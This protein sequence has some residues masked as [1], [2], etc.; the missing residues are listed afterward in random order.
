MAKTQAGNSNGHNLAHLES[1][2][3]ATANGTEYKT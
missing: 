2:P 3:S 1:W